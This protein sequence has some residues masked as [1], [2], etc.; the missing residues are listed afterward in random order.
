MNKPLKQ[1][2]D[3]LHNN[4]WLA[5]RQQILVGFKIEL[6]SEIV[7]IIGTEDVL[8]MLLALERHLEGSYE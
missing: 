5:L 7:E 6:E 3:Q 1:Y 2:K 4:L 8:K